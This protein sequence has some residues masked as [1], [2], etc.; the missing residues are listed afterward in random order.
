[1]R[2]P[3]DPTR[4]TDDDIAMVL[5]LAGDDLPG[6]LIVGDASIDRFQQRRAGDPQWL[7]GTDR[8]A[9]YPERARA[10]LEGAPPGSSAGGEFPKFTI[11]VRDGAVG[12]HAI[13]KFAPADDTP[14]ARRWS[15]LLVAEH[16][17]ST[18]LATLGVAAAES[19][20]LQSEGRTFLEVARFDRIGDHGRRGVVT[21]ASIEPALLGSGETQWDRS[22]AA[23]HARHWLDAG[24]LDRIVRLF[25]F[26]RMIGNTD[27]HWGNIAFSAENGTLRL[28]P[29]YDMLPMLFAPTRAGELPPRELAP[30]AP[31]PGQEIAWRAALRAATIYWS[32]VAR[33]A[34]VSPGFRAICEVCREK[35]ERIG[36][37]FD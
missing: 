7:S 1:M 35:L 30:A 14:A 5:A 37:R 12:I 6:D 3:E 26:G 20:V 21:L 2:I 32:T 29:V 18:A 36:E 8:Q 15:D 31:V 13:V 19:R 10:A 27:M 22:A 17:A 9:V 11:A 25:L 16:H 34:L 23:L 28:A 24:D 33:D 4:W